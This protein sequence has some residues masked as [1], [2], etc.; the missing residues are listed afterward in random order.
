LLQ[1]C[2]DLLASKLP[3]YYGEVAACW[4]QKVEDRLTDNMRII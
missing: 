4:G 1:Q 2:R 3:R